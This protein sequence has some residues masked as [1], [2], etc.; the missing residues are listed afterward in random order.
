M[1]CRLIASLVLAGALA[2]CG[3]PSW[4]D[5]P[6]ADPATYEK[7]YK[8]WLEGQQQTARDSTKVIGIWPLQDGD[9]P[10]GADRSL[11]IVLEATTAPAR[12]GVFRRAG[13]TVT[14]IPASGVALRT[15][16][17]VPVRGPS[18]VETELALG[19]VR[20][21]VYDMA[22]G[23]RFVSATD[24]EHPALKNLPTVQTYPVD[25]RWRVAA[26]FDAFETSTPIRIADT[27]GGESVEM[28]AGRLTFRIDGHEQ[29][30]VVFKDYEGKQFYTMFKDA[31]NSTTTY[32]SRLMHAPAVASGQFTVVDFNVAGNPPCAYSA[33]TNC[34]LP[35]REN[36]LA[37]AI[38]AGEK[39]F[40]T[41]KGFVIQ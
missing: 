36:R 17:G 40:P 34:P 39:R 25:A 35:P 27:R 7:E 32:G 16:D 9:T 21:E 14:V 20:L 8:E 11:P 2:G 19:S 30:L 28:A 18:K 29:Q 5:P 38:E 33:Y 4:P 37:V 10:F 15:A 3:G 24:E 1:N 26:R 12:V 23:R 22:D 13:A 31:T 41:G 6:A